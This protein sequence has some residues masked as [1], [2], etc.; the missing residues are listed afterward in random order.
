MFSWLLQRTFVIVTTIWEPPNYCCVCTLDSFRSNTDTCISCCRGLLVTKGMWFLGQELEL[1][2]PS[3]IP[4]QTGLITGHCHFCFCVFLFYGR[5]LHLNLSY[6][7]VLVVECW[8][9]TL[10]CYLSSIRKCLQVNL[11]F[12]RSFN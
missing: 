11:S 2:L 3:V 4:Q 1:R 6:N 7:H 12:R 5:K 9:M 10:M 8:V